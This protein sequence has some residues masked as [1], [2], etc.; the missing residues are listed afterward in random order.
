MG[1]AYCSI[2]WEFASKPYETV[3]TIH[4]GISIADNQSTFTEDDLSQWGFNDLGQGDLDLRTDPADAQFNPGNLIEAIIGFHRAMQG[5]L[6]RLTQVYV[7]DGFTLGA[8]TGNFATFDLSLV[9]TNP[10]LG[11]TLANY[12]PANIALMLD[13]ASG[14]FSRR[15][16]RCWLRGALPAGSFMPSAEDGVT[17]TDSGRLQVTTNLNA[18]L[19]QQPL[20]AP[21]PFEAYFGLGIDGVGATPVLVQYAIGRTRKVIVDGKE[22]RQ[23]NNW[24]RVSTISVD[25]AQSRDTRRRN[26]K[27]VAS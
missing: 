4:S 25:D 14:Q 9:C 5:P 1:I 24:T 7:N 12:A 6:V 23:L 2:K 13:K 26:K 18:Y 15:G 8:E 16:G 10:T 21:S 11:T 27:A 19:V 20:S 3:H 17:L 22:R